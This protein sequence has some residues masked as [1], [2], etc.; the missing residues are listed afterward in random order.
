MK[1]KAKKYSYSYD[2][3]IFTLTEESAE[4]LEFLQEIGISIPDFLNRE[5]EFL[6]RHFMITMDENGNIDEDLLASKRNSYEMELKQRIIW[7]FG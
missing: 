4:A 3:Y 1:K 6:A 5:I 7:T 2:R